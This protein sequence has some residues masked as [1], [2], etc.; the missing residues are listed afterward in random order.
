MTGRPEVKRR[1]APLPVGTRATEKTE[2]VKPCGA[3]AKRPSGN[4][5][6]VKLK[7]HLGDD[8]MLRDDPNK[9]KIER[10]KP[11]DTG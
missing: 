11:R 8:A 9:T 5:V 2:P 4:I 7:L 3:L 1:R 10:R 6:E